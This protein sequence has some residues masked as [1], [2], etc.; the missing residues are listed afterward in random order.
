MF[1]ST[2]PLRWCS[3]LLDRGALLAIA[4]LMTFPVAANTDVPSGRGVTLQEALGV[5]LANS[6][7]LALYPAEIRAREGRALQAGLF[8][9]PDIQTELEDFAGSGPQRAF[10]SAQT[11]VSL[12]QLVELGGKR[13]KRLRLA[14][15]D[16]DLAHWDYEVARLNVFTRTTKAFVTT[17]AA[18]ERLAIADEFLEL[19]ANSIRAVEAQVHV[20]AVSPVESLRAQVAQGRAKV[21][22]LDAA[23]ELAT[24]RVAL[25]SSWGSTAPAF[26]RAVGDL[27]IVAEPPPLDVLLDRITHNPD[28]ARWTTEL[29]QRQAAVH[30]EQAGRIPD[31]T[32]GLGGRHYSETNTG[33]L[34]LQFLVPLPVFNRNQGA[35]MEAEQRRV[36][37]EAERRAVEVATR[38]EISERYED[39]HAAYEQ[40]RRLRGT[41]IPQARAAFDGA[42]DAYR[43]GLFR[44]IEALDAQRTLFELRE[45]YVQSLLAYHSALADVERLSGTALT[46]PSND[47][48]TSK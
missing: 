37:A 23:R 48:G 14:I 33:A 36:K 43:K 6:P 13:T 2:V 8:P 26:E 5:S 35:I 18:Q 9:N 29:D 22:R 16:R 44:Y 45:Q 42:M 1:V 28:L 38:S 46:A 32:V 10:K 3:G 17:L 21:E 12:A 30:L 40:A 24:A 47:E 41:T 19:A 11:T 15:L 20:G 34:V 31:V 39:L 25:A 27:E 4:L 7:E